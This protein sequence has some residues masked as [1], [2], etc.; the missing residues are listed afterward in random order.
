MENNKELYKKY[1]NICNAYVKKL[2]IMYDWYYDDC[3]WVSDEPG[4]VFCTSGIEY[5]LGMDDI[6]TIVNNNVEYQ[7]FEEWWNYNYYISHAI[8]NHPHDTSYHYINLKNWLK[9]APQNHSIEELRQ[10]EKEY[11]SKY[12]FGKK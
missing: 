11:W 3:F 1:C 2:C 9:G 6:I 10:E 4:G 5:S 7:I 12:N 8:E